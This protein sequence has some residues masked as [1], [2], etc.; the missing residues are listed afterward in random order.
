MWKTRVA[1]LAASWVLGEAGA[2]AAPGAVQVLRWQETSLAYV[3]ADCGSFQILSDSLIDWTVKLEDGVMVAN[4]LRGDMRYYNSNDPTIALDSNWIQN[5]TWIDLETGDFKATIAA[6]MV[7]PGVGPIWRETGLFVA[8]MY[9]ATLYRSTGWD[10]YTN[11]NFA[12]PVCEYLA[13]P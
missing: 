8:N 2:Q 6:H 3:E 4:H 9:T 13:T 1:A 7:V 11:G 10:D 12:A 5:N